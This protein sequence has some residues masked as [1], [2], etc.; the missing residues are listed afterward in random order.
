[1]TEVGKAVGSC[2]DGLYK[3][4]VAGLDRKEASEQVVQVADELEASFVALLEEEVRKKI[5]LHPAAGQ[6]I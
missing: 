5:G 3:R 6:G 4:F 1:M 2:V